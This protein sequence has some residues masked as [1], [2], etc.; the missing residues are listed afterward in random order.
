MLF[1]ALIQ[2]VVVTAPSTASLVATA[3]VLV[4]VPTMDNKEA[5]TLAPLVVASKAI[6]ALAM[7]AGE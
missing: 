4:G 2:G 3:G 6:V 1:D 5:V 7:A